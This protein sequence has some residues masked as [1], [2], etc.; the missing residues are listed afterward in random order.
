M[1]LERIKKEIDKFCYWTGLDKDDLIIVGDAAFALYGVE[2][3]VVTID[4]EVTPKHYAM[5]RK[6]C[7]STQKMLNGEEVINWSLAIRVRRRHLRDAYDIGHYHGLRTLTGRALYQ[8]FRNAGTQKGYDLA[9][10]AHEY[11]RGF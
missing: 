11:L 9:Y 8:Y 7:N 2:H 5:V 3:D 6:I 10:K 4:I 1:N